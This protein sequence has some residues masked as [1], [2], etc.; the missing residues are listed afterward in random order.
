MKK[1]VSAITAVMLSLSACGTAWMA[2]ARDNTELTPSG[3]PYAEIG[4]SIDSYIAEREEGLASCAVSVFDESGVIYEGYYGWEDMDTRAETDEETVYEWASA[5]KILVWTSVMQQWERGNL[6]LDA[7]IREYLP[8]GF[9][10][11][12][13]YPDETITM[14]NLMNHNAGFQESMYENQMAAPDDVYDTLEDAVRACESYQAFHVGEY[15]AYSNWGTALAAYIVE[16]TSGMDYVTYVHENIFEPL[17]M[18]HSS[19]D[20]IQRDNPWVG[21]Q[22]QSLKCYVVAK[23]YYED[24]GDGR[25][26]VQLFPVGACMSTLGDLSKLG[27]AFV[28]EDCPLFEEQSTRDRMF[29]TTSFFGETDTARNSHGLWT[30][31]YLVETLGHGG[32]SFCTANLEFDPES[33]LGVAVLTNE[34]G[35]TAFC[36]GIPVLLYGHMADREEYRNV[37]GEDTDISG[38][39]YCKRSICEGAAMAAQYLNGVFP[40]SRNDDGTYAV[41]LFGITF[42]DGMEFVPIGEHQYILLDNGMEMFVYV[43]DG[44]FE[45]YCQDYAR[46][47]TGAAPTLLCFGFIGLGLL[48]LLMLL[49]KGIAW[50]IRKCRKSGKMYTAAKKMILTQQMIYGVSGVIFVLFLMSSIASTPAFVTVSCI[51]AAVLGMVSLANSS[52][53]CYNT[54]KSDVKIHAKI[55]QYLWAALSAAYAVFIIAMQLYCFWKL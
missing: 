46:S 47:S 51:L 50:I 35:E 21:K 40:I 26:A 12:L 24:Y 39:Y 3:I 8:E 5:S 17:G 34:A 20:P 10:T 49:I 42:A 13:Q 55:K 27:Q 33:G 44:I 1:I 29:E 7:D 19:I 52:I 54:V 2:S 28:A 23:D 6:N 31:H 37:S 38:V 36:N 32:N 30:Q 14:L 15:T 25:C 22:R 16:Q 9:L 4:S 43:K 18:E 48:C 11:K 53:L 41:K 45:M